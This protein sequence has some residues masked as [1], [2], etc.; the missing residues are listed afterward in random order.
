M[1]SEELGKESKTGSEAAALRTEFELW[2]I[3][4]LFA[5]T[6]ESDYDDDSA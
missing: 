6:V 2:R 5:A 3:D 4:E 1:T